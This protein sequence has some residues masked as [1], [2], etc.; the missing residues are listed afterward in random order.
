MRVAGIDLAG[1]SARPTGFCVLDGEVARTATLFS[2]EEIV[3]ECLEAE[4]KVVAIDAPLALPKGRKSLEERESV[5][6]RECD[7]ALLRMGIRFFPVTLGPMRKLTKRGMELKKTLEGHGLDVIEVYPGAAQDVLNI[8]RKQKGLEKLREGLER[9][10]IRG[11]SERNTGDE[12]DAVTSAWVGKCYLEGNYLALGDPDEMLM[13]LPRAE[14]GF[15][16][17]RSDRT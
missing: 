2:D 13:I 3:S 14:R 11:T 1:S 4:P 5:H 17:K 12:L 10:G 6:L 9:L 15:R 8:P 7:R 16:N